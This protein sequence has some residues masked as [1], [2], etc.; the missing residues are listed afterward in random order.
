MSG[1][2]TMWGIIIGGT[3]FIMLLVG[4]FMF[5]MYEEYQE[6]QENTL[7]IIHD[8]ASGDWLVLFE[9][10][11]DWVVLDTAETEND[12]QTFVEEFGERNNLNRFCDIRPPAEVNP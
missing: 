3:I 8:P 10:G 7:E 11:Q 5:T 12:A 6:F 2:R 1:R 9:C 4:A